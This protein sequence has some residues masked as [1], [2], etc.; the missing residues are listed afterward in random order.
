MLTFSCPSG[1]QDFD[2]AIYWL[3][4]ATP[5]LKGAIRARICYIDFEATVMIKI[6]FPH[7]H[8]M[9]TLYVLVTFSFMNVLDTQI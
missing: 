6:I 8:M 2:L 3:F 4:V 9:I 7:K 5:Y 1:I